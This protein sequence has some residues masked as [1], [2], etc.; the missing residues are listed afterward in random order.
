MLTITLKKI[1]VQLYE[2]LKQSARVNRRSLNSEI[3]ACLEQAVSSQP[4]DV[5]EFLQG[6]RRLR[7]KTAAYQITDFEFKQAK[8]DGRP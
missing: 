1:P 8:Q 6:A 4:V 3:L 7:E 2:R 5:E